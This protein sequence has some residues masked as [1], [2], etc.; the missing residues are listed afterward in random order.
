MT[1]KYDLFWKGRL[2]TGNVGEMARLLRELLDGRTFVL[3]MSY[4]SSVPDVIVNARIDHG[5]FEDK[6][7]INF[8]QN[9]EEGCAGLE[10]SMPNEV[11]RFRTGLKEGVFDKTRQGPFVN[12]QGGAVTISYLSEA[13]LKCHWQ[14]I[15]LDEDLPK[16]DVGEK[17]EMALEELNVVISD[18]KQE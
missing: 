9:E 5:R 18:L 6:E 12:F 15:V 4:G 3:V 10:I 2:T 1:R 14:A 13:G 16:K 8:W 17:K 7:A 11:S